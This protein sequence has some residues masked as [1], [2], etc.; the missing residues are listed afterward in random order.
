MV[1]PGIPFCDSPLELDVSDKPLPPTAH[2]TKTVSASDKHDEKNSGNHRDDD[3]LPPPNHVTEAIPAFDKHG[4]KSCG[5]H[6]H[7][8]DSKNFEKYLKRYGKGQSEA[9]EVACSNCHMRV[10]LNQIHDLPCGEII[11]RRCLMVRAF[12]VKLN[13]EKHRQDIRA[14]HIQRMRLNTLFR[15]NPVMTAEQRKAFVRE[16]ATIRRTMLSL[17]GLMCCGVD[18][19]LRRFMSCMTPEV[20]QDL[21]LAIEWVYDRPDEQKLCIARGL[22]PPLV[23]RCL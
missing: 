12:N 22:L 7:D 16:Q 17:A 18:M 5:S 9:W 4:E 21:W 8:L 3:P 10:K 11:C 2:V 13:I 14:Q 15:R 1:T 19:Q 23:L 20:S 6:Q